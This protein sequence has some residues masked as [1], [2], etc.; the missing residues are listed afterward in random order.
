MTPP[1]N[2]HPCSGCLLQEARDGRVCP[3]A[4]DVHDLEDLVAQRR[5]EALHAAIVLEAGTVPSFRELVRLDAQRQR[6]ALLL[7][8]PST[9]VLP[10]TAAEHIPHDQQKEAIHVPAPRNAQR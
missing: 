6:P 1:P 3:A 10:S 5:A 2:P 8:A 9:L 4:R 7:P